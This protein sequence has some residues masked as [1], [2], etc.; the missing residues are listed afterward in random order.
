MHRFAIVVLAVTLL[1]ISGCSKP[2]AMEAGPF[3]Q[4]PVFFITVDTL[5]A[6]RLPMYGFDGVETPNLEAFAGD[7]VLY[8]R[9]FAHAPITLPSHASVMTGW[10]PSQ[11]GVR[12]NVAYRLS[13]DQITLAEILKDKGFKT[14][15]AVSSMVLRKSTGIAQ[16]FDTYDDAFGLSKRQNV[17]TYQQRDGKITIDFAKNWLREQES[18]SL[19]YWLH[20]FE[21]HTPYAPPPPFDKQYASDLYAGEIA[22]TDQLLGEFFQFLK[23]QGLY[24]NAIIILFSDHGE[25]LGDHGELEH[26]LFTYREVIHVPLLVKL[27]DNLHGGSRVSTAAGLVDLKPTVLHLLGETPPPGDGSPLFDGQ[28][29]NRPIYAEALTPELH[30]GWHA[31]RSVVQEDLHYI[32]GHASELFDIAEDPAER[33]NLFGTRKIPAQAIELM[34]GQRGGLAETAEISDQDRAMLESLGYTGSFD[35]G[36]AAKSLSAEAFLRMYNAV[37]LSARLINEKKFGEAERL[38]SDLVGKYPAM[39]NARSMLSQTLFLQEKYAAA[40][41][42]AMEGLATSPNHE[43]LLVGLTGIKLELGKN[44]EAAQLADRAMAV[45]PL[46]SGHKLVMLFFEKGDYQRAADYARQLQEFDPEV[47]F[48]FTIMSELAKSGADPGQAPAVRVRQVLGSV[49]SQYSG[50]LEREQLLNAL[51][52]LGDS[53]ARMGRYEEALPVFEDTLR[54]EPD[55]GDTRAGLSKLHASMKNLQAAVDTLNQWVEN[56]PTRANYLL[57]AQTMAEIGYKE[58]ETFYRNEAER[59]RA[60]AVEE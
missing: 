16:G 26:G 32:E 41:H 20:L 5:R 6:D 3:P 18:S 12:E 36:D 34:D 25:G 14:A 10:L 53:L 24:D 58:A 23:A 1:I 11:H 55:H 15:A 13:E 28:L 49:V 31:S 9:A 22:Y 2:Q 40:E 27:P 33:N 8:E 56:Y 43:G 52:Y 35:F 29:G 45:A 60:Q 42:V 50:K 4:A 57:A 54:I 47:A 44:E 30:F 51:F 46:I 48:A 19:F 17:R 37:T 39:L 21:P 7:A 38:L 59:Y